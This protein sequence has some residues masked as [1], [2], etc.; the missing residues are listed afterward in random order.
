MPRVI[1]DNLSL[2]EVVSVRVKLPDSKLEFGGLGK[3][4]MQ[5]IYYSLNQRDGTYKYVVEYA[6]GEKVSGECG[7]L[8]SNEIGK[9]FL[10]TLRP[11]RI[12]TCDS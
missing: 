4:S 6:D 1:V 10:L 5:I 3:G 12:V 11:N 9:S 2:E 8:T 7:Y